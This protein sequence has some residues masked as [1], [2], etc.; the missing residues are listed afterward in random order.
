LLTE[1]GYG[2]KGLCL[3]HVSGWTIEAEEAGWRRK[4]EKGRR[5]GEEKGQEVG[6][7]SRAKSGRLGRIY[8][9]SGGF[10]AFLG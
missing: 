1:G 7:R 9:D 8:H 5:R 6:G 3:E 2:I 4:E 10:H